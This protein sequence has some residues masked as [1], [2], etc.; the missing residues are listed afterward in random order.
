MT[1][2]LSAAEAA[3]R[4]AAREYHRN[5]SRGKI[6]VTPTKPL[7]NQ[8]DLSLAYS[9]GGAYPCLEIPAAPSRMIPVSRIKTRSRRLRAATRCAQASHCAFI[10]IMGSPVLCR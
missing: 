4:D 7:S 5:P 8:R 6:S 2:E 10:S 9:P 3:L 1:Q